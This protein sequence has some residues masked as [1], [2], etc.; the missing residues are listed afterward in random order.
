MVLALAVVH[1][2]AAEDAVE[3]HALVGGGSGGA[4]VL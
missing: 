2:A 4:D 1:S 3:L